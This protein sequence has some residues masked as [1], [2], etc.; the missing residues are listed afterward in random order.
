MKQG[1]L[2]SLLPL[3][4]LGLL[5]LPAQG[6][7]FNAFEAGKSTLG[8]TFKQMNVPVDGHFKRFSA[9]LAFDPAK[10]QAAKVALDIDLTSVDAGS[11]EANDEVAGK[12]WFNTRTFPSAHFESTSVKALGG[13][14]YEVI[15]KFTL[16]GKTR[17]MV[18]PVSFRQEGSS[19]VFDGSLTLKRADYAIGEGEWAAFDTVANEI[20]VKF[21][22]VAMAAAVSSTKSASK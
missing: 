17:D 8:F 12:Q 22:V 13:N 3:V 18:A 14:R 15:G 20:Y 21:H 6:A 11:P 5:Q 2:T 9:R 7:E 10:P 1:L 16:K 4:L 19:A